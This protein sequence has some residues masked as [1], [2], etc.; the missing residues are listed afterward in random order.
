[1]GFFPAFVDTLL[2]SR[3][4][5]QTKNR[6][7]HKLPFF[8]DKCTD[9]LLSEQSSCSSTKLSQVMQENLEYVIGKLL[10]NT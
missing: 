1:M 2:C 9:D 4:V 8:S 7:D 10:S 3:S 5:T 6:V